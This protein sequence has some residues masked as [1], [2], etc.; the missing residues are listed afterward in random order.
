MFEASLFRFKRQVH[1]GTQNGLQ[2]HNF[3]ANW[4]CRNGAKLDIA[5]SALKAKADSLDCVDHMCE[6]YLHCH[7]RQKHPRPYLPATLYWHARQ[8]EGS[9]SAVG[10]MKVQ[11]SL[12]PT[13]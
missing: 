6:T 10:C 5:W 7:P 11:S 13:G 8:A 2:C 4:R 1:A 3:K 9:C 12:S